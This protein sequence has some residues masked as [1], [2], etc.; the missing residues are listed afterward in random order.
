MPERHQPMVDYA[1]KNRS[2]WDSLTS[3]AGEYGEQ[4]LYGRRQWSAA[5]NWGDWSVPESDLGVL[6]R[7]LHD[8]V[9]IE[10]GCGTAYISAWLKR[11][12]AQPLAVDVSLRQLTI[13][14][15]LQSEFQLSFPLI[16]ADAERVPCA[17]GSCDLVI[18]E[19]GASSW[20]MPEIWVK[21]ASRLLR[22]GGR[23]IFLTT[24]PILALCVPNDGGPAARNLV[25]DYFGLNR[26]E[27]PEG[28][29]HFELPYGRWI[30]LLRQHH[31]DIER[32]I[33][34]Q[35]PEGSHSPW[36]DVGLDWARRW[37]S[38]CIWDV[39]KTDSVI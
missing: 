32:L 33:E 2:Y 14:R 28:T 9:S 4:V 31:F 22:P 35:P 17:D 13:A 16:Q 11:M 23:L 30:E 21:E 15:G 36:P 24:S 20:S 27:R 26:L 29:T 5:P 39:R 37:P 8:A 12:G 1:V 18:S 10:L 38:E 7:G 34:I 6:P 3:E 19:Y 25:R